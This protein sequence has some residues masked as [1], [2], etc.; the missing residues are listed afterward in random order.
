MGGVQCVADVA[1]FC[2]ESGRT[3]SREDCA[4]LDQ[5]CRTGQGCATCLI[6]Q[7]ECIDNR[8]RICNR[9]GTG[10]VDTETC[11]ADAGEY[12]SPIGC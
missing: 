12:C 10:Y 9:D 3:Q 4:E 6:G 7:V 2:T 1:Y 11:D 5:R 8:P